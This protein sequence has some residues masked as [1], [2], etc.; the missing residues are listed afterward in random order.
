[1]PVKLNNPDRGI[2]NTPSGDRD[3]SGATLGGQWIVERPPF[4]VK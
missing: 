4:S 1:M 2:V 3:Q